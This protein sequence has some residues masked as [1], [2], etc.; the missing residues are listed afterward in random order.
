M[1]A[2]NERFS[3]NRT[4]QEEFIGYREALLL[5]D[6]GAFNRQMI[7]YLQRYN[8][9]RPHRRLNDMTL[10]QGIVRQPLY[11]PGPHLS[12]MYWT[13]TNT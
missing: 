8:G 1:N 13:R 6:I 10:Y 7:D 9:E 3:F 4:V 11:L 12:G 2:Y 5:E